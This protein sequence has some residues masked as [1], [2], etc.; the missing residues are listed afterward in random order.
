MPPFAKQ[1]SGRK[2]NPR[3]RQPKVVRCANDV[4]EAQPAELEKVHHRRLITRSDEQILYAGAHISS[5]LRPAITI[6]TLKDGRPVVHFR[7]YR[8]SGK[9]AWHLTRE[10]A[11]FTLDEVAVAVRRLCALF[12][13]VPQLLAAMRGMEAQTRGQDDDQR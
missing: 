1:S 5:N 11:S 13:Y 4:G 7:N 6:G 12:P 10:G 3:L 2:R 9:D 8:S